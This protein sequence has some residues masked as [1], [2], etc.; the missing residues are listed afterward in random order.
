MWRVAGEDGEKL[1]GSGW[2][3]ETQVCGLPFHWQWK[4]EKHD[5]KQKNK[6]NPAV[7]HVVQQQKL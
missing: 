1:P 7:R 2:R 4:V 6:K 3:E 5:P